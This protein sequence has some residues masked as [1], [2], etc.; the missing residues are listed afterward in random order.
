MSMRSV[1]N[2]HDLD[3]FKE[4]IKWGALK[5]VVAV[6]NLCVFSEPEYHVNHFSYI[7]GTIFIDDPNE[8]FPSTNHQ[9]C[10]KALSG[11]VLL[12]D[13][14]L[15]LANSSQAQDTVGEALAYFTETNETTKIIRHFVL[16]KLRTEFTG[17]V[18]TV[19]DECLLAKRRMV[20]LSVM[21]G[22][23]CF[24]GMTIATERLMPSHIPEMSSKVLRSARVVD[25]VTYPE[26]FAQT[27]QITFV[28]PSDGFDNWWPRDLP[29]NYINAFYRSCNAEHYSDRRIRYAEYARIRRMQ[30][31]LFQLIE[32]E[33]CAQKRQVAISETSNEKIETDLLSTSET[34]ESTSS[35]SST[36]TTTLSVATTSTALADEND[37]AVKKTESG[38]YY[39]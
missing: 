4:T 30:N 16:Y 28:C 36:L 12:C 10:R 22:N 20:F 9:I 33:W 15:V 3:A 5:V 13:L 39:R 11:V 38:L 2:A 21:I 7:I 6:D 25:V 26:K 32:R 8:Q 35:T 18:R 27:E 23:H 24:L 14:K 31:L 19:C 29:Y 17:P 34:T 1:Y 37:D